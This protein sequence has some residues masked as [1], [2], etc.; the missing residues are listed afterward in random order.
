MGFP[1]PDDAIEPSIDLNRHLIANPAATFIMRVEVDL[2]AG[3]EAQPGD[4]LILDRSSPPNPVA[5][6]WPRSPDGHPRPPQPSPPPRR[7]QVCCP[8]SQPHLDPPSG[9]LLPALHHPLAGA[10]HGDTLGATGI[11]LTTSDRPD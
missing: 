3:A 5:W 4:L 1:V 2:V 11:Q 7:G 6:W 10:T 9:V 8:G